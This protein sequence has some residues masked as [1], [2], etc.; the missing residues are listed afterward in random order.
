[1][2]QTSNIDQV[3]FCN[4]CHSILELPDSENKICCSFC[5][6]QE[7]AAS[8]DRQS[9]KRFNSEYAIQPHGMSEHPKDEDAVM[10]MHNNQEEASLEKH[11]SKKGHH[12]KHYKDT[13]NETDASTTEHKETE[14][15][16]TNR[17]M[18]TSEKLLREKLLKQ[19]KSE[20]RKMINEECPQCHAPQMAYVAKQLRNADE[21]Q[22]IFYECLVCDF[23]QVLHS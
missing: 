6:Y 15:E 13:E 18:L 4:E 22:T 21:G 8:R 5:G 19:T 7:H 1:M 23:K 12:K 11:R 9:T 14:T 20:S 10:S 17:T 2:W 3:A 16:L